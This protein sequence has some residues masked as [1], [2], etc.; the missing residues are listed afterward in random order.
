MNN[1]KQ[2]KNIILTGFMGTGKTTVGRLLAERLGYEFLDT[3]VTIERQNGRSITTIFSEQGE[4]AFR[5][6][7]RM[8][9]QELAQKEGM[10][11]STGGRMMLD[12]E[13]VAVLKRN[14]RIFCLAAAPKTILLRVQ[15]DEKLMERPL[16]AVPNPLGRIHELLQERQ[17]KY[18][19]FP[20]IMTDDKTPEAVVQM[21][22]DKL[23]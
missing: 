2:K 20:Q 9:A 17:E 10:V 18:Q 19:Q 11:I 4:A 13:N 23:I 3:D 16:L 7:E 12:P 15:L 5:H 21:I 1:T 8:L 6:M 14:G 22:I